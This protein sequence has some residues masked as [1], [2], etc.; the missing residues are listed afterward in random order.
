MANTH[1]TLTS[2]FSDM[3][4]AIREKS[5]STAS[6]V[7]DN[8]PSAIRNISCG[9]P[10]GTKWTKGY[11]GLVT[12][13]PDVI[14]IAYGNG[15]YVA[16]GCFMDNADNTYHRFAYSYDGKT[17]TLNDSI[18]GSTDCNIVYANGKFVCGNHYSTDGINWSECIGT[19]SFYQIAYADGIWVAPN[20]NFRS[21]TGAYYSTDGITWTVGTGSDASE[22]ETAKYNKVYYAN[23]I[24]VF[25]TL[26]RGAYYSTDGRNWTH[27][28]ITA[29][30]FTGNLI[31]GDGLW[32][33]K[34][35]HSTDGK[36]WVANTTK[37]T[38]IAYGNGKWIGYKSS[39]LYYSIDGLNWTATNISS[40]PPNKAHYA[41]GVWVGIYQTSM[42]YSLDGI[43]W[44]SLSNI[45][46][47]SS[48]SKAYHLSNQN[49][50][51]IAGWQHGALYYSVTWEHTG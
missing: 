40:N 27:S 15:I 26:E 35:Y 32:L 48:S 23:G 46:S 2:L 34:S 51:W 44:V 45:S 19:S 12:G 21:K 4:D 8:F 11:I 10:N 31:F 13:S 30:D 29:E 7:A 3:A 9:F 42:Y 39:I 43:T 20:G 28:N 36:T 6:I 1:T 24:W 5:G 50:I 33:T 17:W 47:Y 49:G 14:D 25:G 16:C 22:A 38:P 18:T 37:V 41:C